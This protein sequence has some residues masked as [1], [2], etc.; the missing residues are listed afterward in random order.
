MKHTQRRKICDSWYHQSWFRVLLVLVA[1][2]MIVLG[3]VFA[4]GLDILNLLGNIHVVLRLIG[5]AAYVLVAVFII[6][7]AMSYKKMKKD[8]FLICQHCSHTK[9]NHSIKD[10]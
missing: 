8:S 7:Y 3:V 5:G 6:H 4:A 10:K 9:L 2:D 1:V